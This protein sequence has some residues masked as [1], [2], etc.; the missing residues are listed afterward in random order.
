MTQPGQGSGKEVP[1]VAGAQDETGALAKAASVPEPASEPEAPSEPEAEA[2]SEAASESEP[3][4]REE[5]GV[6]REDL[7]GTMA[8][9]PG[10]RVRL[11]ILVVVIG[12][13]LL[14]ALMAMRASGTGPFADLAVEV[15]ALLL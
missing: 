12:I 5:M 1:P 4:L 3:D 10:Q 6:L 15:P 13:V 2:P 7:K 11:L 14:G 8:A 9:T